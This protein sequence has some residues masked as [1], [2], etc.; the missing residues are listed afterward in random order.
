MPFLL[1][2]FFRLHEKAHKS[3][4]FFPLSDILGKIDSYDPNRRWTR[5]KDNRTAKES[6]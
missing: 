2:R 1:A 4:F 3:L 5:C 6:K